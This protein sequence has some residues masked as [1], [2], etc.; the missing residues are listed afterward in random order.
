MIAGALRLSKLTGQNGSNIPEFLDSRVSAACLALSFDFIFVL[1]VWLASRCCDRH[2]NAL[3]AMEAKQISI[4][5]RTYFLRA[6]G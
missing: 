3:L 4:D 5:F 1:R 6:T 2:M